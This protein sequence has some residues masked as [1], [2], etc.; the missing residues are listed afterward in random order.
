MHSHALGIVA[1]LGT[2]EQRALF[3]PPV[4][5]HGS[6]MASVGSEANPTG[7]LA[8][9]SRTEF[10]ERPGGG[11][12]L[13]CQK[14]FASLAPAAD[15]LMIWTAVPG[16]GPYQERSIIAL[17]PRAAPEVRADRRVGCDGDARDGQPRCAGHRL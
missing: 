9:I 16:D 1:A 2:E 13:T 8:D 6:L 4:V 14:Y 12:R 17:V 15:E 11:Y 3:L 7:K 10:E 5:E